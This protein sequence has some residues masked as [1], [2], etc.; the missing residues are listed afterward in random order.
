MLILF[1]ILIASDPQA[2]SNYA[3]AFLELGVGARPL[4]MGSAYVAVAEGP[5]AGY[6]N[7]AGLALGEVSALGLMHSEHFGGLVRNDFIGVA[8]AGRPG[9]GMGASL[10]RTGVRGV[11][12]TALE[13]PEDTLSSQ[14]RPYVVREAGSGDY[15]LLLSAAFSSGRLALGGNFKLLYRTLWR[16]SA[17]GVGLDLGV[18]YTRGRWRA[19]I[20]LRDLSTTPVLWDSGTRDRIDPSAEAGVSYRGE[21]FKG[22]WT[23]AL[24]WGRKCR[25][26]VEYLHAGRVALRLGWDGTGLTAGAGVSFQGLRADYAFL[27]HGALGGT[28]RVS[29]DV[30]LPVGGI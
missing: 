7:P 15:A 28:H 21:A 23:L 4:G 17:W 2:A 19:G 12:F 9:W 11:K 1:L 16:Y 20:C 8:L 26:G 10:L 30:P 29:I 18:L 6:W 14:N 24:S 3:G 22:R 25:G 13:D 27:M 5:E